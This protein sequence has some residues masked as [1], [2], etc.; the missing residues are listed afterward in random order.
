MGGLAVRAAQAALAE[1]EARAVRAPVVALADSSGVEGLAAQAAVAETE[2]RA[3]R[4]PVVALAD[5]S[6][7]EGLAAQAAAAETEARAVRAAVA[8]SSGAEGLAVPRSLETAGLSRPPLLGG[9][10]VSRGRSVITTQVR[11]R[12]KADVRRQAHQGALVADR[13]D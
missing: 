4:A 9:G 13:V 2:A 3:V 1:T 10:V 12:H 5:S 7:V 6:G 8:R 11:C